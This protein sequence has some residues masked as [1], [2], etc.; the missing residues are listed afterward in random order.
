MVSVTYSITH[1]V[2]ALNQEMLVNLKNKLCV[3]KSFLFGLIDSLNSDHESERCDHDKFGEV[4]QPSYNYTSHARL[5]G[6][7]G[8]Y[9]RT[10]PF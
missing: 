1:L 6:V 10:P 5:N 8:F 3:K 7:I 9:G 4:Y 2:T